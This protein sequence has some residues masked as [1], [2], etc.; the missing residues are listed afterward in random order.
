MSLNFL[1]KY[2]R[3]KLLVMFI[4]IGVVPFVTLLIYIIH[5]SQTKMVDKLVVEQFEKTRL[6]AKFIDNRLT[7]LSNEVK[8]LS[9]LDVMDDLL[10]EDMDKRVSRLL[11][12]KA[13]DLK[14]TV[15]AFCVNPKGQIVASSSTKR[16][17]KEYKTKNFHGTFGSYIREKKLYIYNQIFASFDKKQSLG[18]LVF[19]YN[20]D[21]LDN[22]LLHSSH[23]HAYIINKDS[24]EKI[25]DDFLLNASFIESQKSIIDSQH[26]IVY[27][28]LTNV[29]KDWYIVYA[30]DKSIAL[31]FLF[32]F[33]R[34]ML[35]ISGFIA[36]IIIYASFKFSKDVVK[37]IQTL[38]KTAQE[39]TQ[40]QNYATQVE[41]DSED[42]LSILTSSFNDMLQ[43]TSDALEKLEEE[44]QLRLK[45]F[46][47][48]IEVFNTIIQTKDEQECI[49][50]ATQQI[51]I[52]T[53][54][55]AFYFQTDK[56]LKLNEEYIKLYVTNFEEYK[57]VYFGSIELGIK[58]FRDENEKKFYDSIGTMITLQLD[59]IRLIDRT[60]EAS[61]AKSTFISSMSH[62]LR[63][64]LN[65]II[66]FS[67]YMITCE[68][69]NDE[70]QDVMANVESSAQYLLGMINDILDIAKIEAGKM[71]V[72][73]QDVDLVA[74]LE[75]IYNM[76]MPLASEKELGFLFDY[77]NFTLQNY[78]TDPKLFQ[79]VVV[80]L[81]SNAIKFT[82]QGVIEIS[83]YNDEQK[84]YVK[85]KD[86]GIGISKEDS[87][88]LFNDFSQL[89]NPLQKNHQGT[90]LGLSI[91]KKMAKLLKGDVVL[92]SQGEGRGSEAVFYCSLRV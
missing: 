39:I 29:L 42:E 11:T 82:Q 17:Q 90:G 69:L 84:V 60:M 21:D 92:S 44:N 19:E 28:S 7:S 8:F 23:T 12:Q 30:V 24:N 43:T 46:I 73:F 20:L 79:Q 36:L 80:N 76:L 33:I 85:I 40:T 64:P 5:L 54:R 52:L 13:N 51:K 56:K 62:E 14:N 75:G 78:K 15:V 81:I 74:I 37:P 83:L 16:L 59:R 61:R 65:S 63:T 10:V 6:V 86:T 89:D 67:Q 9:A 68:E 48:L 35:Y 25:G 4:A 87:D 58:S 49:N 77:K 70:Q 57:K 71:E 72:K 32:D 45:R 41:I 66:G 34:F 31:E 47:Q 38:T 88:K 18:Y 22:Y 1:N 55:E 91:S 26:I 3:S 50:I 53:D 2:L 27:T